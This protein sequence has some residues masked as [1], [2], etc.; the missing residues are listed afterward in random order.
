M[1]QSSKNKKDVMVSRKYQLLT[2][3]LLAKG[4]IVVMVCMAHNRTTKS[5][6]QIL[7]EQMS[8]S[9]ADKDDSFLHRTL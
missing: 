7:K 2:Y 4:E 9:R 5:I 3:G 6:G 1:Y 8:F